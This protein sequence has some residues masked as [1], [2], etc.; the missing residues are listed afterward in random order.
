[1]AVMYPKR[2]LAED[3]KSRAEERLFELL[4]DGLDDRWEVFHSAS[5]VVR[6]HAEGTQDDECD[7]VLCHPDE[8]IVCLEVK[9]GGVECQYGEW[10]RLGRDGQRERIPDP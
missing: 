2:L 10:Y 3:V 5:V 8:G 1:M 4:R 6:D 9:G 7:F